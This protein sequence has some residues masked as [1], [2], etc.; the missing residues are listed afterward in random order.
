MQHEA[1]DVE[2]MGGKDQAHDSIGGMFRSAENG[3]HKLIF[4]STPGWESLA[5]GIKVVGKPGACVIVGA[6]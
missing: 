1:V 2:A 5:R 6:G 3:A 4:G